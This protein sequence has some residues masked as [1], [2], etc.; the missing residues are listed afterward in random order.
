MPELPRLVDTWHL[1][2]SFYTRNQVRPSCLGDPS[3]ELLISVV[4]ETKSIP[5]NSSKMWIRGIESQLPRQVT[6]FPRVGY[7]S[8]TKHPWFDHSDGLRVALGSSWMQTSIAT[9]L[10]CVALT[11]WRRHSR[12]LKEWKILAEFCKAFAS[13]FDVVEQKIWRLWAQYTGALREAWTEDTQACP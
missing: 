10:N 8:S 1:V 3:S 9:V 13:S 6:G 12:H 11:L 2:L 5:L 4:N 7:I